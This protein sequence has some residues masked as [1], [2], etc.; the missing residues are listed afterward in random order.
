MTVD[1]KLVPF[2]SGP[3]ASRAAARQEGLVRD[4]EWLL[5]EVREGRMRGIL[6]S[7]LTPERDGWTRILGDQM[8][9]SEICFLERLLGVRIAR[10][11]EQ[12]IEVE[13][14]DSP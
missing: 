6:I 7:A 3:E 2:K 4:I 11:I 9:L 13:R 14:V 5:T 8:S 1:L 10:M 12:A